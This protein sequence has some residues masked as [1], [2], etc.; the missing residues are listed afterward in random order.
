MQMRALIVV[1]VVGLAMS[2]NS[3]NLRPG[4]CKSNA[5]CPR[6]TCDTRDG[7]TFMCAPVDGGM[8]LGK[9][10]GSDDVSVDKPFHCDASSQCGSRDGA[11][12]F[13]AVEAGSCVG[14]LIDG[15][16]TDTAKPICGADHTCRPCST[17]TNTE[18]LL[19]AGKTVCSAG[20]CVECAAST[21]CK[22]AATKPICGT[23]NTCR[24]CQADSE[25]VS[26]GASDPGVCMS[27]TDGHCA[28][29]GETIYVQNSTSGSAVCSDTAVTAGSSTQPFCSMQPVPGVLSSTH[30]LVVVRGTV[31]GG[32]SVFMGQSAPITSIVG[33]Q[34]AFIASGASPGLSLQ[35]GTVYVRSVKFSSSGSIGINATGGT[36]RLDSV[37]VDSCPTGGILLDG[38]QFDI[39]NTTVE[40]SG[41][42]SD[43]SWG[44]IRVQDLPA[45]ASNLLKMNL[46]TIVNNKAPGL[47]CSGAISGTGIFASGNTTGNVVSACGVAACPAAG[48]GCGAQ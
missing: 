47:S 48:I 18:C 7:G 32:T 11:A 8:D 34:N 35:S 27:Q 6:S 44:G 26:K 30:D 10:D 23:G 43:L 21:D 12:P 16:C 15:D 2:C 19:H 14:C 38:A 42:S 4:Y 3:K 37:L 1:A 24:V 9:T 40:N 29:S 28:T 39:E 17:T 36:L 25:C 31:S 41:P 33:Q 45:G 20:S 13:C 46:V 22:T 5:D